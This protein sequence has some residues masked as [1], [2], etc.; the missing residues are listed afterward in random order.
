MKSE[1]MSLP[2]QL[3]HAGSEHRLGRGLVG[4][5]EQSVTFSTAHVDDLPVYARLSNTLNHAEVCSVLATLHSA[6]SALVFSSGMA[7]IHAVLATLLR[8]GDHILLQAN[9]YGSTQGLCQKVLSRWGIESSFVPLNQWQNALRKETKVLFFESIS[10]PYCLPQS[11]S[12]ALAAKQRSGAVLV[13]D[14]TFASPINCR[15]LLHGVDVVIESATKYLNGHS[16]LVCGAVACR[17]DLAASIASNA[18]Y[19]GGFLSTQSC[20]QLLKGLRTLHVRM[21]AHNENGRRFAAELKALDGVAEV[22]HGS[23]LSTRE[24]WISDYAG[25]MAV[26][27]EKKIDVVRLLQSLKMVSDVPSLGG[28]ETTACMPWWTTNRWMSDAEKIQLAIDEQLVRFSV[29]LEDVDDLVQDMRT[30]L[31]RAVRS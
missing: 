21:K 18:M 5:V 6:E 8:P 10:N 23:L 7:A 9:C 29:G 30:A 31:T 11:L 3:Q 19:F 14:N 20:M 16:D 4:A 2:S 27:F 25:M 22:H 26:R 1:S 13:C 24:S 28:T 15:P 17:Q 12:D